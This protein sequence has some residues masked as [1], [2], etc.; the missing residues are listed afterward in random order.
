[1]KLANL[2]PQNTGIKLAF[3]TDLDFPTPDSENQFRTWAKIKK[4]I[5]FY[6]RVEYH[7]NK[8]RIFPLCQFGANRLSTKK[9]FNQLDLISMKNAGCTLIAI[10]TQLNDLAYYARDITRA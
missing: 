7:K 10:P 5:C 6:V 9:Y 2:S 8:K 3:K 1:M 4:G